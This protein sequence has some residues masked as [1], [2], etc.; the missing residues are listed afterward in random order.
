MDKYRHVEC[1]IFKICL[2]ERHM[3]S[4]MGP[5]SFKFRMSDIASPAEDSLFVAC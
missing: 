4:I 5:V 1:Y 2:N 3:N